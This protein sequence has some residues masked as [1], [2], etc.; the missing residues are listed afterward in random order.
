VKL[1]I[2]DAAGKS[3][4]TFS[5]ESTR[6]EGAGAGGGGGRR[7]GGGATTLPKKAGMNRFI[8]DLR[9]AGAWEAT[10]PDGGAGGPMA[11]PGVY[12]LKLTANGAT[13]A[14]TQRLTIKIDPR[15]AQDN[16]TP[17]DLTAQL[18]FAL[19]VRDALSE[20][21]KLADRLKKALDA[22]SSDEAAL[23]KLY[24]QLVNKPGPYTENMLI[25]QFQNIAREIGQAD[26]KIGASAFERYDELMKTLA[27]LKSQVEKAVPATAAM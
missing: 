17:A 27:A 22:K 19:K 20:V 8:W 21:N 11:A 15:V 14:S 23:R 13:S 9:Y 18:E 26:Q 5:S 24:D 16:V 2:L 25:A 12:T 6:R 3:I 4:R 7:R 1:E 10:A